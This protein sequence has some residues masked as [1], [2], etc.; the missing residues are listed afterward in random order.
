M[1]TNS[2][3][4]KIWNLYETKLYKMWLLWFFFYYM[5]EFIV[6]RLTGCSFPF[7]SLPTLLGILQC[8]V[9]GKGTPGLT[10]TIVNQDILSANAAKVIVLYW[11]HCI[12]CIV[13]KSIPNTSH[14]PLHTQQY[15]SFFYSFFVNIKNRKINWKKKIYT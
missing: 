5:N 3:R 10:V 7:I 8:T 14:Q 4:V 9:E 1:K 2:T 6:S 12:F 15:L 11:T 13:W